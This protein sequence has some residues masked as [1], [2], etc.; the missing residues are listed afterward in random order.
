MVRARRTHSAGAGTPGS[1]TALPGGDRAGW[2]ARVNRASSRQRLTCAEGCA[3]GLPSLDTSS[4][5]SCHERLNHATSRSTRTDWLIDWSWH[6]ATIAG[7]R[8]H[9][10]HRTGG[11]AGAGGCALPEATFGLSQT[12]VCAPGEHDGCSRA[13]LRMH[14]PDSLVVAPPRQSARM[15][16]SPR[17]P[18]RSAQRRE[19]AAGT[20]RPP[21]PSARCRSQLSPWPCDARVRRVVGRRQGRADVRFGRRWQLLSGH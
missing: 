19:L 16:A 8:R 20:P 15:S 5:V 9:P 21:T 2:L 4:L 3:S 10:D 17:S 14:R 6:A 1:N 12:A 13:L 18:P 11:N 7:G